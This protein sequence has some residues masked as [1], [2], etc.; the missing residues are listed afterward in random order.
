MALPGDTTQES[1]CRFS[2]RWLGGEIISRRASRAC[3]AAHTFTSPSVCSRLQLWAATKAGVDVEVQ[4]P[5]LNIELAC[6]F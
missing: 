2:P 3:R 6:F 5:L 4:P 1:R